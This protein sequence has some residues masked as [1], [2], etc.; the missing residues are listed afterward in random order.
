MLI[1]YLVF[2]TAIYSIIVPI[3][4]K[5]QLGQWEWIFVDFGVMLLAVMFSNLKTQERLMFKPID[6]TNPDFLFDVI[7]SHQRRIEALETGGT[8]PTYAKKPIY[9]AG[10]KANMKNPFY[11][12]GKALKELGECLMDEKT[13]IDELAAKA[14]A[15][16]FT[17]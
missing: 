7:I 15:C 11:D 6:L 10:R 4:I 17:V 1:R 5:L 9:K 12:H 8:Q 14:H 2:I 16:G 13:M 3:C